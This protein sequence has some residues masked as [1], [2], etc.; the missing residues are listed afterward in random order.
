VKK[1]FRGIILGVAAFDAQ[2]VT[3]VPAGPAPAWDHYCIDSTPRGLIFV[4]CLAE[5]QRAPHNRPTT[6]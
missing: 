4:D 3:I 6:S 1:S 5:R 2:F